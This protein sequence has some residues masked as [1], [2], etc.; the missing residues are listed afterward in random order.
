MVG[1]FDELEFMQIRGKRGFLYAGALV[2]LIFAIVCTLLLRFMCALAVPAVPGVI[3][4]KYLRLQVVEGWG[5]MGIALI[6]NGALYAGLGTWAGWIASRRIPTAPN[7][8][9]KCDYDLFGNASNIC[10]ECGAPVR[11]IGSKQPLE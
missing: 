3:V 9:T 1:V 2:G 4:A 11:M 8:C 6:V 7:H 10:P 5:G